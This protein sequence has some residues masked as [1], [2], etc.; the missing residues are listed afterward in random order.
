MH[1][2]FDTLFDLDEDTEVGAAHHLALDHL[3]EEVAGLHREP[4][5]VLELL[6]AEAEALVVAVD[7][8]D[9]SLDLI[10]LLVHLGGVLDALAPGQ[11][12]DVDQSVDAFLDADEDAE[13]G[14]VAHVAASDGA[15][16][17]GLG[18]DVPGVGLELTHAEA[19]ALGLDVYTEHLGLHRVADGDQLAG[20]LDALVPGHLGDVD[21]AFDTVFELHED[22]VV[23][24]GDHAATNDGADRVLVLDLFPGIGADLLVPQADTLSVGVE[25]KDLDLKSL[26]DIHHLAG[27]VDATVGHVRDVEKAVDA[28]EV[29]EGAVVGDVLDDALHDGADRE[30]L[31]GLGPLRLA[32]LFEEDATAE[33]DVAP[34]LVELDDAEVHR[35]ADELLELLH[36][37]QVDLRAG[38]EGLDADVDAEA[39]LHAGCDL[40]MHGLACIVGLGDLFPS[41]HLVGAAL[42]QH[43]LAIVLT[44][45]VEVDL[46]RVANRDGDVALFIEELMAVDVALGLVADVNGDPVRV[47]VEH[48]ASDDGLLSDV[49]LVEVL[50]EEGREVVTPDGVEVGVELNGAG[51]VEIGSLAPPTAEGAASR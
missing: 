36:G 7:V 20:V 22:A 30:V 9:T 11:I 5:I 1:E 8:E 10:A 48:C 15:D 42:A 2:T 21:Q 12:A 46:H 13:V 38:E 32:L 47:D 41:L 37:T 45:G 6:D 4:R 17:V 19:D 23:G 43:E 31:E 24:H 3:A 29:H 50:V 49:A 33:H 40:A 51:H 27:M 16:R 35:L 26:T 25:L 14:D 28:A 18:H 44:H 34:T 39:T